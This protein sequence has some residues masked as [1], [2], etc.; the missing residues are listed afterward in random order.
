MGV[1]QSQG[2]RPEIDGIRALAVLVVTF[3]HFDV[4]GF[5]GGYIGVDIFFVISG[6]LITGIIL[7][8]MQQGTF[9]LR[10]FYQRRIRRIFPALFAVTLVSIPLALLFLVPRDLEDFGQSV[11][12]IGFFFQ[13][14]LFHAE[15]GYFGGPSEL[16]PLLHTWSLAVEEQFYLLFPFVCLLAIKYRLNV[17]AVFAALFVFSLVYSEWQVHRD[18]STAFY[19]LPGRWWELMLGSMV[20]VAAGSDNL[21]RRF[22]EASLNSTLSSMLGLGCIL[23]SFVTYDET[24]QFPGVLALLPCLGTALLILS[25]K[26]SSPLQK[27]FALRPLVFTGLISYSLY[28]WHFPVAA[29]AKRLIGRDFSMLEQFVLIAFSIVLAV[30]SWEFIEKPFRGTESRVNSRQLKWFAAA[31]VISVTTFGIYTDWANGA[32]ERF[33]LETQKILKALNYRDKAC[34]GKPSCLLSEGTATYA[35]WGD[36]HADAILGPFRKASERF[37]ATTEGF[38]YGG[39]LPLIGYQPGKSAFS[40]GCRQYNERTLA[41]LISSDHHTV[42]LHGRWTVAIEQSKFKYERDQTLPVIAYPEA[43]KE[44]SSA[45]VI[46]AALKAT[47]DA[48]VAAGKQVVIVGPIP[49]AGWNVP[50]SLAQRVRF[51]QW[52]D[53][54]ASNPTWQEFSDRNHATLQILEKAVQSAPEV[55]MIQPHLVLCQADIGCEIEIDNV[56]LY[57]DAHHLSPLGAE[58]LYEIIEPIYKNRLSPTNNH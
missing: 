47:I 17:V 36:S 13:N 50:Y 25:L 57:A 5:D 43:Q 20:A 4:V 6:Y 52:F 24:T 35:V 48:L 41:H 31:C 34:I 56:P 23:F 51:K 55:S 7:R 21:V 49:E 40:E 58:R 29:F 46:G 27:L 12:S 1:V 44:Q 26:D 37:D 2:Y 16:K 32:W 45:D 42:F 10:N 28:L 53:E 39:C 30:L 15:S 14:F 19:L 3:Y 18:A 9:T 33:D 54:R 8:E 22:F 38:I 11:V